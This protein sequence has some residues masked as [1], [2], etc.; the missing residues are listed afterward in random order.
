[1]GQRREVGRG[2]YSGEVGTLCRRR[3]LWGVAMTLIG[4]LRKCARSSSYLVN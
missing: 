1:M 3:V 4:W 2:A